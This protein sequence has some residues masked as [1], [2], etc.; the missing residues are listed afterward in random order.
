VGRSLAGFMG[1]ALHV[2]LFLCACAA[3]QPRHGS[4]SEGMCSALK[5]SFEGTLPVRSVHS[6]GKEDSAVSDEVTLRL[7]FA[8]EQPRVYL[9]E[10]GTWMEAKP[11]SFSARCVGPSAIVHAIDSARDADGTWVE[12]WVL[13]VTVR[14]PEKLLTRWI[15]MVNNVNLPLTNPSS[16]FSSEAVG[17]LQRA[18]SST[19]RP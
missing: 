16:K 18:R 15:R 13:A 4:P 19:E 1:A 8:G 17:I 5:G 14:D 3:T 10:R 9:S 7:V 2:L 12:S 6:D 11:G